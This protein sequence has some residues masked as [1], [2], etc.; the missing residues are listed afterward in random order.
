MLREF[1]DISLP[2]LF[3]T[4]PADLPFMQGVDVRSYLLKTEDGIVVIYNSPG[5][6]R[7]KASIVDLGKPSSILMSHWHEAMYGDQLEIPTYVSAADLPQTSASMPKVADL[8][9]Y[10]GLSDSIEVISTPGHT[11]GFTMF[12]WTCGD[13]RV[14]FSGDMIWIHDGSWDAV[15]LGE[16]NRQLYIASL[17]AVAEIE[18]DVLVPWVSKRAEPYAILN[19][20]YSARARILEIARRVRSGENA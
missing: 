1:S 6:S 16:S 2:G 3:F 18:F 9:S 20:K 17:E 15:V 13:R 19:D 12:L 11:A 7:D 10:H 4:E 5:L 14:L 8:S